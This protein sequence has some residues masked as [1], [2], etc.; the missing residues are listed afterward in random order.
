MLTK[1]QKKEVV[2][3]VVQRLRESPSVVF[4][5]YEGLDASFVASQRRQLAKQGIDYVVVK[6]TLLERAVKEVGLSVPD[7]LFTRMTAVGLGKADPSVLAK[8]FYKK[9]TN[10]AG[11]QRFAVK[12]AIVDGAFFDEGKVERL[13]LLPTRNELIAQVCRGLNG[14][15][16]GLAMALQQ[17]V[18]SIV[19]ALDKVREQKAQGTQAA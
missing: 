19:Y 9:P 5:D 18:S 8:A 16:T 17:T 13:A 2:D 11:E 12:G 1:D 14:P 4:V 7:S 15:I 3:Q 6:N 10:K